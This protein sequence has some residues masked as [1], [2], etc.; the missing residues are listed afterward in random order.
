MSICTGMSAVCS[1]ARCWTT[2]R[3]RSPNDQRRASASVRGAA[4]RLSA[5]RIEDV[6]SLAFQV[7]R[8]AFQP[9]LVR[10]LCQARGHTAGDASH[11]SQPFGVGQEMG[12]LGHIRKTPREIDSSRQRRRHEGVTA[13]PRLA[14]CLA[15]VR[16]QAPSRLA[17]VSRPNRG[18]LIRCRHDALPRRDEQPDQSVG[19]ILQHRL[20]F[21]R[22]GREAAQNLAAETA[23]L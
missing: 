10:L 8:V 20:A 1:V 23:A 12:G 11:R 5:C 16:R 17:D 7:L 3:P 15:I 14:G 6:R 4:A 19:A 9:L 21:E 22:T 2:S 18:R 13:V